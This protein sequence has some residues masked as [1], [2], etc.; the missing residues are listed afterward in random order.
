MSE[1]QPFLSAILAEPDEDAHRLVFADWLDE[2]GEAD[3]AEFIRVQCRLA[4]LAEDDPGRAELEVR[5]IRLLA[6]HASGWAAPW[7]PFGNWEWAGESASRAVFR[8]GFVEALAFGASSA[9]VLTPTGGLAGM[10]A[11]HPIRELNVEGWNL[12]V[13]GD[14]A[15]REELRRVESLTVCDSMHHES[16][17]VRQQ[18]VAEVETLLRSPNLVRLREVSIGLSPLPGDVPV[19]WLRLQ[20]LARVTAL[21]GR[22]GLTSEGYVLRVLANGEFPQLRELELVPDERAGYAQAAARFVRS[23]AWNRLTG[24]TVY[25]R[26]DFPWAQALAAAPLRRLSAYYPD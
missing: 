24:L 3:R 19:R 5:E 26:G 14:L 20:S 8:R 9:P 1:A 25:G 4:R 16:T 23:A 13:L 15:G 10:F 2:R 7:A 21:R 12:G 17:A 18:R 6:Q 11:A 22:S